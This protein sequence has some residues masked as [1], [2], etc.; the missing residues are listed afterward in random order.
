MAAIDFRQGVS[1]RRD[2]VPCQDFGRLVQ[3]DENTIL[4]V[5][6]DGAGSA[7][8]SHIGARTAV[9]TAL[10]WI[11]DRIA[12][13]PGVHGTVSSEAPE[14][15]F[16]GL[17][18]AVYEALLH[19]ANENRMPLE[20]LACTLTAVAIAPNGVA[21]AQI[22][23][24][25]VVARVDGGDYALVMEAVRGEYANETVFTTDPDAGAALQVRSLDGPI[26]FVSAATD[27]LADLSVDRSTNLPHAGFFQPIDRFACRTDSPHEIHDGIR[28]FLASDRLAAQ[29]QDDLTLLVCG[30]RAEALR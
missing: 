10:P 20:D 8:G 28:E 16:D 12:A 19:A 17:T 23:D 30:W 15:L 6:A 22:G 7:A 9:D 29:T 3:I 24:G 2:G 1:H 5:M 26:R 4:A 21:A 18:R 27:G 14:A 25:A 11:R 13:A